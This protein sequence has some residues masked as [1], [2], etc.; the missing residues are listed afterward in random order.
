M[1]IKVSIVVPT[2]REDSIRK[3]LKEWK[4]EFFENK[5]FS[6]SVIIVEDNPKKQFRIKKNKSI[7]H[8]DWQDIERD[9]A[10]N[11]WIIPRRSDCIRSYGYWKAWLSNP[12]MIV[13]LDDD[14]Y[15]L[16]NYRDS[17]KDL[18]RQQGFLKTHWK[19]LTNGVESIRDSWVSTIQFE[20]PRGLPYL[21]RV[22][23][24][25][26]NNIILNHGLWHNVPDFDAMTQLS[27]SK[28]E[29]L[30]G[31]EINQIIPQNFYY[32]MCGMNLA[33]KPSA[34]P[35]LYFLLMGQSNK[36]ESWGFDRFGDIWAGIIFKKIA[37]HLGY[38]VASGYPIIWH[39]KASNVFANLKKE[40]SG[41]EI[42]ETFWEIIDAIKL[43]GQDF[44][45]CYSEIASKL[46]MKG[47]YWDVLKRAMRIWSGLFIQS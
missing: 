42:N 8:Y 27:L 6:V 20:R 1:K 32:P 30:T 26:T 34:T 9:L 5:E 11:S 4:G 3:F 45:E 38:A 37:D 16:A 23:E 43:G 19:R 24:I 28:T 29:G 18:T 10:K 25:H 39:A 12:D 2:I 33:W 41:I 7:T 13:T 15:P 44:Q 17:S 21:R 47:I 35:A 31:F 14:C 36:G 40:A 22:K 46:S